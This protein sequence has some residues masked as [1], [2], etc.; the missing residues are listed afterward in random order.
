MAF[1][2]DASNLRAYQATAKI[3][4]HI[5][6]TEIVSLRYGYDPGRDPSPFGDA[7]LPNNVGATSSSF[8]SQGVSA[9]LTSTLSTTMVNNFVFGWNHVAVDFACTGLSD[10]NSV[11]PV[12]QFGHGSEFNISPFSSFACANDTLLSDGQGRRTSTTSYGDNLTWVRGPHT[13]KFGGEFRN[14][15]ESGSSNFGQRRQISTNAGTSV[16]RT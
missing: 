14:V 1:F 16:C 12:D 8:I 10:L 3:D 13:L 4:H 15:H 5:T 6:E 11:Y 2:P 9:N 7:T